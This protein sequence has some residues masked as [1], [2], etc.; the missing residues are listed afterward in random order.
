MRG[1]SYETGVVFSEEF[2]KQIRNMGFL[3]FTA[4]VILV[5]LAA[6]PLTPLITDFVQDDVVEALEEHLTWRTPTRG[7]ATPTPRGRCRA[8][9]PRA[10]AATWT[11][12][13]GSWR[14]SKGISTASTC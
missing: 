13:P 8:S 1:M 4:I 14:C 11:P 12:P 3:V 7:L 5:M 9:R 2:R 10:R 6:I